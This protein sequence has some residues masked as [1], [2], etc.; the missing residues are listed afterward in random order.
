LSKEKKEIVIIKDSMSGS[1][2]EV[3]ANMPVRIVE[4]KPGG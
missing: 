2:V 1:R 4:K 3:K